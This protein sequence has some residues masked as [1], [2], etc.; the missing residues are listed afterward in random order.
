MLDFAKPER[1]N[2]VNIQPGTYELV[3]IPNPYGYRNR[4]WLIIKDT[5]IGMSEG[6][7]KQWINGALADQEGHPDFG[8]PIDCRLK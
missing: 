5:T 7:W 2:K 8:K 4:T 1:E 3:R 6:A